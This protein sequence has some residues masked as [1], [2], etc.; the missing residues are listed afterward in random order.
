MTSR[1]HRRTDGYRNT[2]ETVAAHFGP[3]Q[4]HA[5]RGPSTEKRKRTEEPM[6]N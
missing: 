6:P 5:T 4:V 2:T 1:K 3:A